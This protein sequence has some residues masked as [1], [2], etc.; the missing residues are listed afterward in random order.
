[1]LFAGLHQLLRPVLDRVDSLPAVQAKALRGAFAISDD[2]VPPDALL[3]GIAVLTLLS[4]LS[5]QSPLLVVTDDAQ[6]LDPASLDALA[7]AARRL[8]SERLPRLLAAPAE[9]PPPRPAGGTAPPALLHRAFPGQRLLA[10]RSTP[11]AGR[12][13]DAQPRPPRGRAR[14]QV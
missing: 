11:E 3:T 8:E 7:F 9:P 4:G 2:P 12:L 6:W 5:E 14:E 1:L 10:P 13:L